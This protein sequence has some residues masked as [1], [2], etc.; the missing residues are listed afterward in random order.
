MEPFN[1]IIKIEL[2]VLDSNLTVYKRKNNVDSN[3]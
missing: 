1:Q 3:Y 2:L